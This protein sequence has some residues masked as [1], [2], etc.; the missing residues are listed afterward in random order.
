[1]AEFV[2]ILHFGYILFV[3]GGFFLIWIGFAAGWK[4]IRNRLFRL[5]HFYAMFLVAMEAIFGVACP[6]TVF[7]NF[8]RDST[9]PP[10]FVSRWIHKIMFYHAPEWVFTVIYLLMTCL[11]ILTW[12]IVRP[13]PKARSITNL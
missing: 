13:H 3:L 7:E 10:S 9:D 1:M 4:W 12:F 5:L 2:L 11:F 8:L 6:L